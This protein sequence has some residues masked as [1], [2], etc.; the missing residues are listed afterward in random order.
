[1]FSGDTEDLRKHNLRWS[2]SDFPS[3][4]SDPLPG[5]GGD[6]ETFVLD[7][8]DAPGLKSPSPLPDVPPVASEDDEP[9]DE[10]DLDGVGE[11]EE[12]ME[13]VTDDEDIAT[14]IPVEQPTST[15]PNVTKKPPRVKARREQKF[16]KHGIAVPSLPSGIVKKIATQFSRSTGRGKAKIGKDSL[17][18]LENATEWFFEQVG[19]DLGAYAAHAGRRTIDESDVVQLMRR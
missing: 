4:H 13:D 19:E 3:V 17:Q 5:N 16:S 9:E 18:A 15:L 7:G 12:E 14:G 10:L 2:L 6:D 11:E 1:M 8:I